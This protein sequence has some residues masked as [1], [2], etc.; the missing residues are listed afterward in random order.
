MNYFITSL[1]MLAIMTIICGILYPIGI[2]VTAD[3]LFPG[4][5]N[6]SLIERNHRIVGS[7]LIGQ[8][9]S[10]PEFFW[11][12]PSA[13]A[14]NPMPS[15]GSNLNPLGEQLKGTIQARMDSITKFHGYVNI[16]FI[17][18]DLLFSSGSGVDPHIS[19]SAAYFQVDR[20]ARF[21]KFDAIQKNKLKQLIKSSI[22]KPDLGIFGEYRVNIVL[23]NI[24]LLEL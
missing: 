21:R 22:E 7:S 11:G 23:L 2:F 18:K 8:Q 17:P 1:K 13:I 4:K 10:K 24:K 15:G 3:A 5:S 20:I 12:R 6:G 19:P 9:F 14:N 16:H